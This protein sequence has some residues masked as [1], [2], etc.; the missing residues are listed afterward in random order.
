[1]KM[2]VRDCAALVFCAALL[3][4]G[5]SKDENPVGPAPAPNQ[6]P[7]VQLI[8]FWAYTS[9]LCNAHYIELCDA[10]DW[11]DYSEYAAFEITDGSGT[12][13][14][15]YEFDADLDVTFSNS[16]RITFGGSE[17]VVTNG[18]ESYSG[19]WSLS[20]DVLSMNVVDGQER[21]TLFAEKID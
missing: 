15:Y 9:A 6:P 12:N 16:G 18:G 3:F 4:A 19:T 20:G 13:F 1:M 8:G 2:V 5:C 7:P 21:I 10:L 14:Y 17:F 11:E